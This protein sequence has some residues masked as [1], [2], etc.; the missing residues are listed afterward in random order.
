MLVF[1]L[2][3]FLVQVK[4]GILREEDKKNAIRSVRELTDP[5]TDPAKQKRQQKPSA[6]AHGNAAGNGTV[7]KETGEGS[8][9]QMTATETTPLPQEIDLSSNKVCCYY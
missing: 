9:F 4:S 3:T 5:L 7:A 6:V 2:F 1:H 8:H